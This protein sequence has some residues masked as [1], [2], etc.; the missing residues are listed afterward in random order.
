LA[1][2]RSRGTLGRVKRELEPS[3]LFVYGSLLSGEADHA[4][5]TGAEY[6]GPA[7]TPAEYYLVE[8]NGFPALVHGGKLCVTGECYRADAAL[9]RRLDVHKQHPVLFQRQKLTLSDGDVAYTYMMTLE[10]VRGRRRLKSGDWRQR[11]GALPAE[12]QS[13]WAKWAR[14]RRTLR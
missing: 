4:L 2:S 10:Q 1:S 7:L 13:P 8:L 12:R 9:L 6:L 14:E 5:L 11:F 3:R